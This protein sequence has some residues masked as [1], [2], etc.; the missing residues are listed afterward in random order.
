MTHLF[1]FWYT[2][3]L[4]AC[5]CTA[6]MP[7]GL[8]GQKR[9]EE[10]REEK[11]PW[12]WSYGQLWAAV[13]TGNWTCIYKALNLRASAVV[14]AFK[15]LKKSLKAIPSKHTKI[16][17]MPILNTTKGD[18]PVRGEQHQLLP[19]WPLTLRGWHVTLG[20]VLLFSWKFFFLLTPV[21]ESTYVWNV[22][23]AGEVKKK[24]ER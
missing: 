3:V 20:Y 7:G 19:P 13:C 16:L 18:C 21:L 10:K 22:L 17:F 6:L 4:P 2:S 8:R 15:L 9:K 24:R 11:I 23:R 14:P 12:N 1:I 5:V